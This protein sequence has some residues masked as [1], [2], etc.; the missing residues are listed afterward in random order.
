MSHSKVS[1]SKDDK[2]DRDGKRGAAAQWAMRLVLRVAECLSAPRLADV[3]Q[4]HLVG[5]Y[6]SGAANLAFLR[7]LAGHGAKVRVPTTLNA[8]SADLTTGAA[9]CYAGAVRDRALEVVQLLS[10]MGCQATLTCAPYFLASPPRFAENIAWAESNAVLFANTV[11]GARTL[12]C[13]Q[14]LDL[15]CALTGRIPYAG[16]MTAEGRQP[17]IVIDASKASNKWFADRIG[18]QFIG[19]AAGI[20]AGAKTAYIKGLPARLDVTSLQGLCASA[21]VSGS[22]S[23]L[24]I[25]G[26]TPEA[27]HYTSALCDC[28]VAHIDD[29]ALI[30]LAGQWRVADNTDPVAVCIGAPHAGLEEVEEISQKLEKHSGPVR[31][32]FVLSVGRTLYADARHTSMFAGLKSRGVTIV[33]DTCTYYGQYFGNSAGLVLTNSMKWAAYA[34]AGPP[35]SPRIATLDECVATAISGRYVADTEYWQDAR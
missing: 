33:R 5:A 6:H 27:G 26:S 11:I 34:A 1:L 20:S 18:F 17:E 24:H 30:A 19:F 10:Q 21:G 8:S 2:A 7:K 22:M 3:S 23:M 13:P 15:A 28:A 14:Y 29:Q 4:A 9:P 31:L 25:E 12:K 35:C 32:P 16:T